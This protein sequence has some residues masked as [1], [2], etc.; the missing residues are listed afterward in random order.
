[1]TS[2]VFTQEMELQI[3]HFVCA[4]ILRV[5]H[6]GKKEPAR[7]QFD[8]PA[9]PENN[10]IRTHSIRALADA[11][12]ISGS[13][14]S[15]SLHSLVCAGLANQEGDSRASQKPDWRRGSERFRIV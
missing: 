14:V 9:F 7:Y 8:I 1:M 13:A 10:R 2:I 15:P 3:P 5:E 12:K 6:N 11:I 4:E